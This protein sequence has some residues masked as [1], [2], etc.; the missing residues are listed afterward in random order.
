MRMRRPIGKK[1][2]FVIIEVNPSAYK[3]NGGIYGVE[4]S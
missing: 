3:K 1:R 4:G 2:G